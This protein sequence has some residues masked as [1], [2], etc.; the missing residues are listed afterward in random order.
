MKHEAKYG[1]RLDDGRVQCG[2]CPKLC[3]MKEGQVGFCRTRTN[4]GGRLLT[5]IYAEVT[6]CHVDPIEKKPL[7]HYHPGRPILSL[8]TKG[9]NFGC[10]FCQNWQIAQ[11][12]DAPSQ[13]LMPDEAVR[14]AVRYDSFGIAYT[15]TEP[16]I[17]FEYVLDTAVL[18]HEQG[19]ENVLVTNGFIC[20]A[21]LDELMPHV[22]AANIDV[23]SF[24]PEFYRRMCKGELAPVLRTVERVRAHWHVELTHLVV[25]YKDEA[26]ILDDV[27]RMRDWVADTLGADTPLHFS[28]Y[29]PH[30]KLELPATSEA[31]LMQARE[32]AL[33][34]L[35]F[36]YIGNVLTDVGADTRCPGC[37]ALLIE[38]L[39]YRT[40]VRGLRN[41]RCEACGRRINVVG[42]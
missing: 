12:A 5:V 9:C 16:L 38:R 24:D 31:L 20:E 7:Y 34:R 23:K 32:I 1:T 30:H 40:V 18:A 27:R 36:V 39:G 13:R 8:G 22:D 15:Y 17:W 35:E 6:G 29:F 14:A 42:A 10:L 4:E 28:R 11:R 21:P 33:E 37:G 19:L 25:P 3:T 26:A 41:G 2:L